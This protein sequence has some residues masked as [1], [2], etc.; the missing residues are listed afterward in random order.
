MA[1]VSVEKR[2]GKSTTWP[3]QQGRGFVHY[4][5]NGCFAVGIVWST[6][7]RDSEM[8]FLGVEFDSPSPTW[9]E[10][11]RRGGF[12][13]NGVR[14]TDDALENVPGVPSGY[15]VSWHTNRL[16]FIYNPTQSNPGSQRKTRSLFRNQSPQ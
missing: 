4:R 13:T 3:A 10:V 8:E 1:L 5:V 7:D 16:L 12:R 2:L 9:Q 14:A 6:D 15:E 11:L